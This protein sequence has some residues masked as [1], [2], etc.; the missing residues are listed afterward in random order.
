M[1]KNASV[2]VIPNAAHMT[3]IDQ[4]EKMTTAVRNFLIKVDANK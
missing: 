3:M 1:S 4:P 2:A